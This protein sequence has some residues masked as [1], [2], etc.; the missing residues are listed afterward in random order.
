MPQVP[1]GGL[2]GGIAALPLPEFFK[3][4]FTA[5]H[6]CALLCVFKCLKP[7]LTKSTRAMLIRE[8]VR[9]RCKF[10]STRQQHDEYGRALS[11][12]LTLSLNYLCAYTHNCSCL[13]TYLFLIYV[14][15][16]C[17]QHCVRLDK[18]GLI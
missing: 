3:T 7:K 15:H 2:G 14:L 12:L 17:N 9:C 11:Y 16:T 8:T 10:I 5:V 4:G 6:F 18:V 13:L 1:K